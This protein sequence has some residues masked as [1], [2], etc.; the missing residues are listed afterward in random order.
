MYLRIWHGKKVQC[1]RKKHVQTVLN[2]KRFYCVLTSHEILNF[3]ALTIAIA[4]FYNNIKNKRY[5]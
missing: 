1:I 2:P 3:C 5:E 4:F